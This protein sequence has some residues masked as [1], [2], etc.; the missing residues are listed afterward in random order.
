MAIYAIGDVQGCFDALT[1]LLREIQYDGERDQLWFVGDLVNRGPQSLETLRFVQSLGERA[2]V[3][4]G[5]HDLHLLAVAEGLVS[6]RSDDT[7]AEI[8]SAP[9]RDQLLR[10][11]RQRKLMHSAAGWVMVHAGLLPQWSIARA[12]ELAAEVEQALRAENYR[13]FLAHMYGN[14]P[15][16]WDEEL[17]GYARLR[18]VVNAMTR[19]RVCDADGVM[20]LDFSGDRQSIP[21]GLF[22]WFEVPQ[23]A[24]ARQPI[25]C[26]HW[27]ALGL[28]L[29]TDVLAI[30]SGCLWGLSLTALRLPE[31]QVIQVACLRSGC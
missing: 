8:L 9:D 31:R 27:S 26:G 28:H 23:R 30:D 10:W 16:R 5:N 24:S 18:V 19:L 15:N 25:V 14:S 13:E 29:G 22:A 1:R 6:A 17:S 12:L 7:L 3:T 2:V 20:A 4:L 21:S 11:L